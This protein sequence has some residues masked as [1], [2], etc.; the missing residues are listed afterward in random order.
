VIHSSHLVGSVCQKS[1]HMVLERTLSAA[2]TG[3]ISI[4]RLLLRPPSLNG[5]VAHL[6][7][8]QLKNQPA[9]SPEED[10]ICSICFSL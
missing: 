10:G 2:E 6:S 3:T 9:I 4:P 5:C 1:D 8:Q 7:S